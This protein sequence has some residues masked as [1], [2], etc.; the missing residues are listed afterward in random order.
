MKRIGASVLS[1]LT[2]IDISAT[3]LIDVFDIMPTMLIISVTCCNLDIS[4]LIRQ[5]VVNRSIT[6]HP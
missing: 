6:V 2:S 5:D 1:V 3:Q 4:S